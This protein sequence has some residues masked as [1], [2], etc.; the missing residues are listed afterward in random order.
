MNFSPVLAYWHKFIAENSKTRKVRNILGYIANSD[1][2]NGGKRYNT[3]VLFL[4]TPKSITERIESANEEAIKAK[5]A[6][7]AKKKSEKKIQKMLDKYYSVYASVERPEWDTDPGVSIFVAPLAMGGFLKSNTSSK[8]LIDFNIVQNGKTVCT[9]KTKIKEV[10]LEGQDHIY[11]SKVYK[12][13]DRALGSDAIQIKYYEPDCLLK[14]AMAQIEMSYETKGGKPITVSQ[15]LN[16]F[17]NALNS[18]FS[19]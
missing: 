7:I 13:Y 5:Q 12:L 16:Y 2:R 3:H 8:Q 10:T 1:G 19:S 11:L 9:A 15:D 6:M 4:G 18:D 14:H 17:I